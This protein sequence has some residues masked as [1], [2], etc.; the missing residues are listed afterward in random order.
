MRYVIADIEATGLGADREMIELAL[1]TWED[2]KVTDVFETLI[3]PLMGLTDFI[4]ELTEI[5][6]RQLEAAPKFYEI[7]DRVAMRL[8]GAVFVSHNVDFDWPMLKLAFDKMNRPLKCKTL[9]T[10]KLAQEL[11]PGMKSYSLDELCKFFRIKRTNRHRALVDAEAA[12]KLFLELKSLVSQR[13]TPKDFYLPHHEVF[14]KKIP[15]RAG[16]LYFKNSES[17]MIQVEAT[18]NMLKLAREMLKVRPEKRIFLET[19][20]IIEFEE[21]GSELIALF[22][23]AGFKSKKW[24]YSIVLSEKKDGELFFRLIHFNR[25][26]ESLWNFESKNQALRFLKKLNQNLPQSSFAWREGGKTKQEVLENNKV[27]LELIKAQEFPCRNLLLWGPGRKSGEWSYVLVKRGE[28][29][30]FGYHELPPEK[31]ISHPEQVIQRKPSH[32][33]A[34]IMIRYLNEHR[35]KK[36]KYDQWRELKECV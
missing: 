22:K 11:I 8:E 33:L 10:L 30:G 19:C 31:A 4:I 32:E 14:L 24:S 17:E 25:R 36:H 29:L 7:A 1:I 16:V 28:L 26:K 20:Q 21:T 6:T 2:G 15:A 18:D 27:V 35:Q 12:M 5:T 34:P 13:H 9:C 3:N 23:T